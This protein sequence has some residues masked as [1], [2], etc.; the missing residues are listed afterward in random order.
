MKQTIVMIAGG[1]LFCVMVAGLVGF[2]FFNKRL[3]QS[4]EIKEMQ[5]AA[6]QTGTQQQAKELPREELG[7]V[8]GTLSVQ[9]TSPSHQSTVTAPTIT[10]RG[11]TSAGAEVFVND[12]QTKSDGQGNFSVLL[13]LEE[14]ENPIIVVANDENGNVGETEVSILYEPAE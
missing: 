14:G 4:K 8:E 12:V 6:I 10:I 7:A 11:K 3:A 2:M 5:D 1:I 9:V 13:T